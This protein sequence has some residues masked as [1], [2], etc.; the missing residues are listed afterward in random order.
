MTLTL[1][2]RLNYL[3]LH[4][5]LIKLNLAAELYLFLFFYS[6]KMNYFFWVKNRPFHPGFHRYVNFL[7]SNHMFSWTMLCFKTDLQS[8][9]TERPSFY[10]K[11]S[12]RYSNKKNFKVEELS[13][14]WPK[15]QANFS[16]LLTHNLLSFLSSTCMEGNLVQFQWIHM[17][18][19]FIIF[20]FNTRNN[21]RC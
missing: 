3:K 10:Q 21:L 7:F 6:S 18:S 11:N 17:S 9:L 14:V 13:S 8:K 1:L 12:L 20:S 15:V 2:L 16:L 19:I 4:W 5:T